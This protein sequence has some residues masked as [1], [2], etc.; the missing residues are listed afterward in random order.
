VAARG[1][2]GVPGSLRV[3]RTTRLHIAEETV[4]VHMK[5]LLRRIGVKNRAQAA[6]WAWNNYFTPGASETG[7]LRRARPL[8]EPRSARRCAATP[9]SE[10]RAP[11]DEHRAVRLGRQP[12]P[13]R[14]LEAR[15]RSARYAPLWRSLACLHRHWPK[16]A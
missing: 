6:I 12:V 11:G 15:R 8:T 7:D 13:L 16:L 5:R 4:K 14:L 1:R 9:K 10:F 2:G 3:D